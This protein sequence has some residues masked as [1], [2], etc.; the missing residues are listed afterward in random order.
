MAIQNK[1]IYHIP[2]SG[3]QTKKV[4]TLTQTKNSRPPCSGLVLQI[5]HTLN[6]SCKLP[7]SRDKTPVNKIIKWGKLFHHEHTH[8]NLVLLVRT[9]DFFHLNMC[10]VFSFSLWGPTPWHLFAS[11]LFCFL[12]VFGRVFLSYEHI[13]SFENSCSKE[14]LI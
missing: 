11:N 8:V 1:H 10:S 4:C 12:Y 14:A 6:I 7:M 9:V 2:Q 5:N 13:K 3:K